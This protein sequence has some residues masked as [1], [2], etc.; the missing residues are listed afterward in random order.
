MARQG[1]L[2]REQLEKAVEFALNELRRA[3]IAAEIR[4]QI[5]EL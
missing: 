2:T 4:R 3:F 5:R 1:K